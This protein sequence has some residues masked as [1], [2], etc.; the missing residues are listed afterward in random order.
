MPAMAMMLALVF[1]LLPGCVA[2]DDP[3][4]GCGLLGDLL[5]IGPSGETTAGM[6]TL[7]N[8][9]KKSSSFN[10]VAYWN[11]NFAPQ[12]EKGRMQYLTSDFMF[13]PSNWGIKPGAAEWYREARTVS[14]LDA[15][16]QPSPAEMADILLYA[17]EPDIQGSCMGTMIGYCTGPCTPAE[18]AAGCPAAHLHGVTKGTPLPNGHCNCWQFSHATGVGFWPLEGC[19]KHQPLPTLW[20]DNE[21]SCITTVMD[22]WMWNVKFALSKGYKYLTTPQVAYNIPYARKF[23]EH[24]CGCAGGHCAC[25]DASCGCPVY[26]VFHFY[27][28]DCQP[29]QG[30]Y[31]TLR[32]RLDGVK[33][34]M[35]DYPFVKGAIINEIGVLNCEPDKHS[36]IPDSGRYPAN[37][38]THGS[39]PVTPT[40]PHG[41]STFLEN[42]MD[43]ALSAKTRDG[44][45]VVKS[46]TWFNIEKD[47]ATYDLRLFD[48]KG[49]LNH[50]GETYAKACSKWGEELKH[51]SRSEVE[52]FP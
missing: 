9:L 11:W 50:L 48:R 33:Q 21:A 51:S 17:N 8:S 2:E 25:T 23:I 38:T 42:V 12:E 41:T 27:G 44:R 14:W 30:D 10:K 46:L 15:N 40:L 3:V 43:I 37:S 29:E 22:H 6:Q 18:A 39:C 32:E 20:E 5:G 31:R 1:A 26:V 7:V 36:C 49:A 16:G 19:S 34:I 28:Y 35:E 52:V 24:A 45:R 4:W 13:M 47:G